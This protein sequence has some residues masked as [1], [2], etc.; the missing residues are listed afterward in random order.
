[1]SKPSSTFGRG[2]ELHPAIP[3]LQKHLEFLVE[4]H[5]HFAEAGERPDALGEMFSIEWLHE[6]MSKAVAQGVGHLTKV[7]DHL[8]GMNCFSV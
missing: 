2:L 4:R 1:M 3:I 5:E 8:I 7:C 6:A